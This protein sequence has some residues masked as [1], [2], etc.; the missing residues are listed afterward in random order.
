MIANVVL[1]AFAYLTWVERK[2]LGRM[3]LRYGPNRVGPFGL[4]QPIA[5]L[6][7]LLGKASFFPAAAIDVLYLIAPLVAG[8]H[9]A[10]GVQRDPVRRHLGDRGLHGHRRGRGRVRSR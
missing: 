6:M 3:H 7:K 9:G 4:L 1:G 2:L 8:V 5:D 10:R